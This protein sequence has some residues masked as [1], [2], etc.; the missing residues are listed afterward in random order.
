MAPDGPHERSVLDLAEKTLGEISECKLEASYKPARV[1]LQR[2]L[3]A[4][5]MRSE[6]PLGDEFASQ[7]P[8]GDAAISERMVG[9]SAF[10]RQRSATRPRRGPLVS[11]TAFE[12]SA[13]AQRDG[14]QGGC[15]YEHC[16]GRCWHGLSASRHAPTATDRAPG[17]PE[18]SRQAVLHVAP[19][20]LCQAT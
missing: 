11:P 19:V 5:R 15:E 12:Q 8:F 18:H 10:E 17:L 9:A 7:E 20:I 13:A 14:R 4:G 2:T 16:C 1:G 6:G 3:E